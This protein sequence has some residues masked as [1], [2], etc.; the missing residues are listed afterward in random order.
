MSERSNI[1]VRYPKGKNK[2]D[3]KFGLIAKY[4]RWNFG[5]RMVSRA[6]WTVEHIRD[7]FMESQANLYYFPYEVE[8]LSRVI[9]TNFDKKDVL[10]STDC[11]DEWKR[12]GYGSNFRNAVFFEQSNND[13]R[14]FIDIQNDVI[15]YAF[16]DRKFNKIMTAEEYVAWN[17]A[18]DWKEKYVEYGSI[19]KE[20]VEQFEANC[21]A[22]SEMAV[23]MTQDEVKAFVDYDY[24]GDMYLTII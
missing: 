6:R 3:N 15:K 21:K 16:V 13:G 12:N 18:D 4:Y 10:I 8:R 9:D 1:Y 7:N 19:T 23:L 11:I 5:E 24:T 14:L 20:D 22:L 2:S 17:Y